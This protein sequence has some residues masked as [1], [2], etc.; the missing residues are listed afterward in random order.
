MGQSDDFKDDFKDVGGFE[1][2]SL[3]TFPE[4]ILPEYIFRSALFIQ[5]QFV[6]I[7]IRKVKCCIGEW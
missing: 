2:I 7:N 4:E 3:S 6:Y 5:K 1:Y